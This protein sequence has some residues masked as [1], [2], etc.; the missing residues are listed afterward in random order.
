M[1]DKGKMLSVSSNVSTL[2][3]GVEGQNVWK[4]KRFNNYDEA[5]S[6]SYTMVIDLK[7]HS[8]ITCYV[9]HEAT[10]NIQGCFSF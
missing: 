7:V 6:Y 2:Y 9:Y 8:R 10:G 3:R 1:L 5:C 4:T